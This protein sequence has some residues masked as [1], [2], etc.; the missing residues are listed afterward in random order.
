M[1]YRS[2][3]QRI[4]FVVS[5]RLKYWRCVY[6]YRIADVLLYPL[7]IYRHR[8]QG[9]PWLELPFALRE[10]LRLF[11]GVPSD[12]EWVLTPEEIAAA[13]A[14]V[15]AYEAEHPEILRHAKAL[16]KFDNAKRPAKLH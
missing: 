2:R 4:R 8:W 10:S 13:K 11:H 12:D 15:A 7:A 1:N 5:D 16:R 6:K 14:R 3:L 9:V